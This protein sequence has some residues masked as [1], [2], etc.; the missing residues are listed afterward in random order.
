MSLLATLAATAAAAFGTPAPLTP[1]V[2]A[3]ASR[4]PGHE[5]ELVVQARP[6][7]DPVPAVRAAGGTVERRIGLIDGLAVRLPAAAAPRL[8]ADPAVRAVSLNAPVRATG[9][10]SIAD[11]LVSAFDESIR[12]TKAWDFGVTGRGVGVAVVDSGVQGDLADFDVARLDGRSRVA[13][14]AVVNPAAATGSD[15][16]GHGTHIAGLIAGNGLARPFGDPVRGHYLGVAPEASLIAVKA[17]D[18]EGDATVLD[19][20]DGLQ[21]VV[22]HRDDYGIRVVNLS[23]SSRIAESHLT[24]PLDAAVEATWN[25]GIVVVTAAGNRGDSDD[26]VSYAPG[27]DPWVIS[28]GGVDDQGT[29]RISDDELAT[30]SSRGV[31]QDGYE[32]PDVVAPG[33]RLVSTVPAGSVYRDLCPQC[34]VEGDY[35]RASGTSMAAA[36]V[37][38]A[39]AD[40]LQ[41]HPDWTPDQVKRALKRR[42]RAI[43]DENDD[44]AAVD[45]GGTVIPEP[46]APGDTIAGGEI[47][48]DR[49]LRYYRSRI[50]VSANRGLPVNE[51]IDPATGGLDYTRTSWSRT[52]WSLAVDPLRTSWSWLSWAR[53]SWSRTSWSATPE[54]CV[55]L[56]RTSWSRTSWSAEDLQS[57]QTECAELLAAIDPT[58]T[59]WSRTS[60][61][62]TSWSTF[63]TQ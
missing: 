30:W 10:V 28:V 1:P 40:I 58:R 12:A 63:F 6:G 61:S 31:T 50:P 45:A 51:L 7:R 41:V 13:V 29:K 3:A 56:E 34:V 11:G 55:E 37:S 47:A 49:V 2:A 33:A 27:N 5:L 54:T 20:I 53:T 42:S 15:G 39:V 60:W 25:A 48:I 4:A 62:R 24:D 44:D 16:L 22:D 18:D 52:S 14:N 36:L 59:S 43:R 21:F 8:A 9:R 32:K 35:F 26:A 57:A 17:G 38:G 19:I 46:A 23:L